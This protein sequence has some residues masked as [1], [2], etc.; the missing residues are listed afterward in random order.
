MTG[1]FGQIR[2]VC[3]DTGTLVEA[4]QEAGHQYAKSGMRY[5]HL[6]RERIVRCRQRLSL[7]TGLALA[8]SYRLTYFCNAAPEYA[9]PQ[10][11][12]ENMMTVDSMGWTELTQQLSLY[13]FGPSAHAGKVV[14]AFRGD[15]SLMSVIPRR[16]LSGLS[17]LRL[18]ST[19]RWTITLD[20]SGLIVLNGSLCSKASKMS[21]LCRLGQKDIQHHRHNVTL[22]GFSGSVFGGSVSAAEVTLIVSRWSTVGLRVRFHNTRPRACMSIPD[23]WRRNGE[24]R[25]GG[26]RGQ[27]R[28]NDV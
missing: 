15:G 22:A 20:S 21:S 13:V 7:P 17:L 26:Q 16:L 28:A 6:N 18:W 27:R 10:I 25:L 3:A 11:L 24:S 1:L 5:G 2:L 12:P 8:V 14:L 23:I 19:V 9:V 4:N